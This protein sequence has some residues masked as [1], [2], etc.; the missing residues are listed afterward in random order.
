MNKETQ[1]RLLKKL[2]ITDMAGDKVM[3]DF[4]SGKYFLLK[5]TAVDIW[6][7]IQSETTIGDILNKMQ[8]IYDVDEETCLN[9][10]VAF[11]N[12]LQQNNFVELA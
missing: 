6:E 9:G 10:I 11:I 1:V 7:C 8:K 3:V 2:D 12:Q 5:G 4:E